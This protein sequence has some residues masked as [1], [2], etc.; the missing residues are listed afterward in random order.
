SGPV[1]AAAADFFLFLFVLGVVFDAGFGQ[2]H[3]G[4]WV[5]GGLGAALFRGALAG[6]GGV[7]VYI[8]IVGG[9]ALGV[10]L[11]ALLIILIILIIVIVVI[12][13]VVVVFVV[14]IVI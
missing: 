1:S 9:V 7:V 5:E 11:L 4:L 8:A 14:V 3:G 12:V 6:G 2:A 13:F 10:S